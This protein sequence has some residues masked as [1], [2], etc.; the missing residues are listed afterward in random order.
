MVLV[1]D[2]TRSFAASGL[3]DPVAADITDVAHRGGTLTIVAIDG[4]GARPTELWSRRTLLPPEVRDTPREEAVLA[5]ALACIDR[6]VAAVV[7]TRPGT[8]GVAGW[9]AGVD[10]LGPDRE[11]ARLVLLTDGYFSAGALRLDR[12]DVGGTPPREIA[13]AVVEARQLADLSGLDVAVHGVGRIADRAVDESTVR[14]LEELQR[15]L[16]TLGGAARCTVTRLGG[17]APAPPAGDRPA[18]PV[19]LPPPGPAVVDVA[20]QVRRL[21]G[22]AFFD[23]GSAQLR[24]GAEGELVGLAAELAPGAGRRAEIVGH[25]A[26]WGSPGYREELSRGRAGAVADALVRLGADP[27]ALTVRGAGSRERLAEDVTPAGELIGEQAARNRRVDV[28][29]DPS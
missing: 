12:V 11:G 9:N 2:P 29:L 8:D 23:A 10:A 15:D 22:N 25:V 13:A 14:W 20:P 19:A 5:H 7:P 27:G 17:P 24:V 21:T 1:V 3:P 4:A 16:C 28:L 26:S 18:D 6:A